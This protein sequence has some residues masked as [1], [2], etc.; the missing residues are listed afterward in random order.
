LIGLRNP[1]R[2]S[3][4]RW[5][6]FFVFLIAGLLSLYK[7]FVFGALSGAPGGTRSDYVFW[8]NVYLYSGVAEILIAFAVLFMRRVS[9]PSKS[10]Q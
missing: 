3:A 4:L 6:L 9:K 5:V 10:K 8:A 2:R 1:E 7:T